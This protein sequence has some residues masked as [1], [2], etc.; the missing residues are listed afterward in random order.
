MS[1]ETAADGPLGQN[2]LDFSK[3]CGTISRSCARSSRALEN[4]TSP[5]ACLSCQSFSLAAYAEYV[6]DASR[7]FDVRTAAPA[8]VPP[9]IDPNAW[10]KTSLRLLAALTSAQLSSVPRRAYV[11]DEEGALRNRVGANASAAYKGE[12]VD[13]VATATRIAAD[14]K[15]HLRFGVVLV[16]Q[17]VFLCMLWTMFSKCIKKG[18]NFNIS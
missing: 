15:A 6:A 7:G 5:F 14:A 2:T 1:G 11:M 4:L 10:P 13:D 12:D 8:A 9:R 16:E 18:V 3:F 17:E